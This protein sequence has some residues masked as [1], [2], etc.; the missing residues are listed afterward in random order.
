MWAT[1][2]LVVVVGCGV[3]RRGSTWVGCRREHELRLNI[4]EG[5][6]Y[7]LA[8]TVSRWLLY[9]HRCVCFSLYCEQGN[10]NFTLS[11]NNSLF[12][13]YLAG[14]LL[15]LDA[16]QGGEPFLKVS[17]SDFFTSHA[18][19]SQQDSSQET[20]LPPM[21]YTH[22]R[23]QTRPRLSHLSTETIIPRIPTPIPNTRTHRPN[24]THTF[25]IYPRPRILHKNGVRHSTTRQSKFR[26]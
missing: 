11:Q 12:L 16:L 10:N 6:A 2:P 8:H 22:G 25:R 23:P 3:E 5:K 26:R 9:S 15:T 1:P 7:G 20:N 4:L 21:R 18:N 24:A 17:F 19:A 14:L 13:P